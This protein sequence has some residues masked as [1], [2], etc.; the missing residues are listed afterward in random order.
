MDGDIDLVHAGREYGGSSPTDIALNDGR[1]NFTRSIRLP[2][3]DDWGTVPEVGLWD[4]DTDGDLDVVLSRAGIL[5]VGTGVQIIENMGYGS[6]ASSFYP[7]VTAPEDYVA[8]HEG[9]EWNNFIENFQ[10]H[11]VD[12]DGRTDIAFIGVD[13]TINKTRNW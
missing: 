11:D 1:G 4:L 9:N 6:Y 12:L 2:K 5:Y 8:E 3:V 7:I 13:Q 10:F